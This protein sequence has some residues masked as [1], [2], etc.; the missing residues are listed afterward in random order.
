MPVGIRDE[1]EIEKSVFAGFDLFDVH[2][3]RG[4]QKRVEKRVFR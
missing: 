2:R 1:K 4:F 3:I